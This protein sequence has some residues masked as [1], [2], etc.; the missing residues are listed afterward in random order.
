MVMNLVSRVD[1]K[2][3]SMILMSSS[4]DVGVTTSPE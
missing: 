4:L 3:S 1:I 2:L